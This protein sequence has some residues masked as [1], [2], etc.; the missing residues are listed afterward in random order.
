[1]GIFSG[2][3]RIKTD[4]SSDF[5]SIY[6]EARGI[7]MNKKRILKLKRNVHINYIGLVFITFIV[8]FILCMIIIL[9]HNSIFL[10]SYGLFILILDIMSLFMALVRIYGN[11]FYRK[12][13][14][15]R[16]DIIIDKR[17]ITDLSSFKD[18]EILFLWNRVE[19]VVIGEYSVVILLRKHIYLYFDINDNKKIIDGIKKYNK[20]ILI[21]E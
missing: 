3:I 4:L 10:V 2:D 20:D 11:Y 1:M 18:I 17:G 8:I 16:A 19:G 9:Q 6:N 15:F 12:K 14:K 5:F 13:D 7:A 21:I